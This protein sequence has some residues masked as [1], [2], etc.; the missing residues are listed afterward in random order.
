MA[1]TTLMAG[2]GVDF[3]WI[4]VW[5]I[6]KI[7][8]VQMKK[9]WIKKYIPHQEEYFHKWIQI[10]LS[11][12]LVSEI[13]LALPWIRCYRYKFIFMIHH[14]ENSNKKRISKWTHFFWRQYISIIHLITLDMKV[15]HI[16]GNLFSELE[17][18]KIKTT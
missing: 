1:R 14:Q 11:S 18:A 7:S 13:S 17:Q 3:Q 4:N 2:L 12:S 8:Q 9:L 10:L 16:V 5:N 6:R 15:Y